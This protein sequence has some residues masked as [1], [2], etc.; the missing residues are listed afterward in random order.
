MRP[1]KSSVNIASAA[2]NSPSRR[3][4]LLSNSIPQKISDS[5]I[6]VVQSSAA[7]CFATYATNRA[8]G[9]GRMSSEST[10]V[11][12]MIIRQIPVLDAQHRVRATPTRARQKRQTAGEWPLPDSPSLVG[13]NS[14]LSA[15]S[16]GLPPPSNVHDEQ[17]GPVAASW[18]SRQA[19]GSL[20]SPCCQCY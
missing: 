19:V 16:P 15:K 14:E 2:A 5:V 18:F 10:F 4:P 9:L 17:R 3:L 1:P 12:R 20:M 7:G 13:Q 8:E 6:E 11:S